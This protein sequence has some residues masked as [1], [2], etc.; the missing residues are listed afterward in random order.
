[1]RYLMGVAF[2]FFTQFAIANQALKN[3]I[4][5]HVVDPCYTQ[6]AER[7]GLGEYMKIDEAVEVMKMMN[8]QSIEK[9]YEASLPVVKKLPSFSERM[10][11]YQIGLSSC[12]NGASQ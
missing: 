5:E 9:M 6:I 1:M 7:D 8:P 2:A 4:L 10:L 11:F 3:E 12:I